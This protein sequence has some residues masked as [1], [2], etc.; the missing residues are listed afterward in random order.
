[1]KCQRCRGLCIV[2]D[3]EENGRSISVERCIN[4][5]NISFQAGIGIKIR[6]KTS[7]KN[8]KAVGSQVITPILKKRRMMKKMCA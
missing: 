6:S 4:C 1:M 5:G 3:V 2:D 7:K 8:K